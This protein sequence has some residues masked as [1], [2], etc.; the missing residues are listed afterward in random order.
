MVD[1]RRNY[2][3][4]QADLTPW[5]VAATRRP[6]TANSRADALV[7]AVVCVGVDISSELRAISAI[8]ES[9]SRPS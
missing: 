4:R 2:V 9:S 6:N 7:I 1:E 5:I 8:E 3:D